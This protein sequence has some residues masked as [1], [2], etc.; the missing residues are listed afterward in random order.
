MKKELEYEEKEKPWWVV[1]TFWIVL[2]VGI[3]AIIW[4]YG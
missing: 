4:F 2:G 3:T 1:L